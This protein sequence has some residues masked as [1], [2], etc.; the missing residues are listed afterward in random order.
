MKKIAVLAAILILL[1]LILGLLKFR[2][3][4]PGAGPGGGASATA[5]SDQDYFVITVAGSS[6]RAA[7]KDLSAEEAVRLA[8][9]DGRPVLVVWDKAYTDA[10]NALKAEMLRKEVAISSERTVR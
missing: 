3:C 10:E 2:G 5:T 9:S 8:K 4:G 1:V 7:G 6:I